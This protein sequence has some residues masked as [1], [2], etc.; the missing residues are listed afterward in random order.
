MNRPHP[1]LRGPVREARLLLLEESPQAA[2]KTAQ[3]QGDDRVAMEPVRPEG[4]HRPMPR[5]TRIFTGT[6]R[7]TRMAA[8][9][10]ALVG[11]P[12]LACTCIGSRADLL[13]QMKTAFYG[14]THVSRARVVDDSSD[15]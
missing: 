15:S 1:Q 13:T 5:P 10:V 9:A 7:L 14:A 8:L 2:W 4:V 3:W 11:A 6:R 12:A